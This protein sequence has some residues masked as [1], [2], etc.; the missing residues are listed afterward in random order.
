MAGEAN[1]AGRP[2]SPGGQCHFGPGRSMSPLAGEA[3]VRE[4]NVGEA[5]VIAP[6]IQNQNFKTFGVQ[7]LL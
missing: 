1:V 6:F 5:N 4:V 3:N 2:M 7:R